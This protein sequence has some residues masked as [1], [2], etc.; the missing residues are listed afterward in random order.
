M[1]FFLTL[2]ENLE[3]IYA[4]PLIFQKWKLK[5]REVKGQGW[6]LSNPS[7]AMESSVLHRQKPTG[8]RS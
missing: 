4:N 5:T 2:A 8:Y 1:D 7:S 6:A 3:M